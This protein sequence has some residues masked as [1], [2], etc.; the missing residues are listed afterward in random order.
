MTL[1]QEFEEW[2]QNYC[3][4][5]EEMVV[6]QEMFAKVRAFAD[7]LEGEEMVEKV[8]ESINDFHTR[9]AYKTSPEEWKNSCREEAKAALAVVRKE[10]GG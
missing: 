2:G 6:L 8:A 5:A 9:Y 7:R 3:K 10:M 4:S 1:L